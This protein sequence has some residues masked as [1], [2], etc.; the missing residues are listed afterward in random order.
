M[1]RPIDS[2]TNTV[3]NQSPTRRVEFSRSALAGNLANVSNS[4][5]DVVVDLRCDAYGFGS[6]WVRAI[7]EDTGFVSFLTDDTPHAP[8]PSV[9][10]AIL[11]LTTGSPVAKVLGEVVSLKHIKPGDCVSYG[12]TWTASRPTNLALVTLGFADGIPRSGSNG[13]P[14]S[15]ADQTVPIVGRIAMDQLVID[16]TDVSVSLGELA[17]VWNSADSVAQWQTHTGRD[18]LTFIAGLSWRVERVWS[19]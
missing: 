15:I 11:G 14:V 8:I 5:D 19:D 10:T 9:T 6:D 12:Y 13:A 18:P 7:S 4:A 17:E 16:V 3:P 1:T 2:A